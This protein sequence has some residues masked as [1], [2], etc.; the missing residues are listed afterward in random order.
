MKKKLKILGFKKRFNHKK[1]KSWKNK[2]QFQK[3][4]VSIKTVLENNMNS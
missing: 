1:L 3:I 2:N 4:F